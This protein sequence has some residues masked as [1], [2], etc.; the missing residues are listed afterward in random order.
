M[1]LYLRAQNEVW[2]FRWLLSSDPTICAFGA[3]R[4]EQHTLANG[5]PAARHLSISSKM[6]Y[7]V[8]YTPQ[9]SPYARPGSHNMIGINLTAY[10]SQ[11]S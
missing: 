11:T 6:G 7:L 5:R 10:F 8:L 9:S 2:Y 4:A 1:M 3:N